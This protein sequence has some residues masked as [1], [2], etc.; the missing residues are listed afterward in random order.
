MTAAITLAQAQAQLD[1]LMAAQATS[2]LTVRYADRS[3]TYREA[4]DIIDQINYWTRLVTE[5]QRTA[6]GASRHG[7]AVADFRGRR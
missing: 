2:T 7:Y 6:R 4:Q 3:I 5:L 1:A